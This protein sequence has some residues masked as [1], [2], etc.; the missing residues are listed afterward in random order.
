[1]DRI[2]PNR[3]NKKVYQGFVPEALENI[4]GDVEIL[5]KQ[6]NW[7]LEAIHPISYGLKIQIK[8]GYRMAEINVFFGKKGF[9]VT[10]SPKTGTDTQ[11]AESLFFAL[12]DLLFPPVKAPTWLGIDL[13]Q[14]LMVN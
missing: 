8:Q 5:C 3:P 2:N 12:H 1:M 7:L 14:I 4:K 10:R 6:N 9:T 11:L 13:Q